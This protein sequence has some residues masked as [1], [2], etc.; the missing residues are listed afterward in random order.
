MSDV[1]RFK[2]FT[3]SE[4]MVL[5]SDYDSL[6]AQIA[7][8]REALE[9]AREWVENPIIRDRIDAALKEPK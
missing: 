6:L 2:V 4:P 1:K 7:S 3:D 5:A 8:L 9:K